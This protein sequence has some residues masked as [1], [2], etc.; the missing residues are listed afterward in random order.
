MARYVWYE[1]FWRNEV[2]PN[3]ERNRDESGNATTADGIENGSGIDSLWRWNMVAFIVGTLTQSIKLFACKGIP[4][5]QLLVA[6]CLVSF[7]FMESFRIVAG[8]ARPIDMHQPSEDA[9][10]RVNRAIRRLHGFVLTLGIMGQGLVWIWT[11]SWNLPWSWFCSDLPWRQ[12]IKGLNFRARLMDEHADYLARNFPGA[13]DI[14]KF[15]TEESDLLRLQAAKVG[16]EVHWSATRLTEEMN[17][18]FIFFM[19]LVLLVGV[20]W[21]LDLVIGKDEEK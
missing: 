20:C 14:I 11:I 18:L 17:I 13:V 12:R 10:R 2:S 16:A 3:N 9:V 4:G 5:T 6:I 15:Y 19:F 8:R 7:L 1:R 21:L